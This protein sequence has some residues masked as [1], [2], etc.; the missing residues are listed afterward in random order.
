MINKDSKVEKQFRTFQ[1]KED[2]IMWDFIYEVLAILITVAVFI[3]IC[4][5]KNKCS[6]EKYLTCKK[7]GGTFNSYWFLGNHGFCP[8]CNEPFEH[9]PEEDNE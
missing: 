3:P 9:Q 4:I 2:G 6:Q 1:H 7:C 8:N 5:M